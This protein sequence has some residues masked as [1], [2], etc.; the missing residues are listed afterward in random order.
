MEGKQH[1]TRAVSK[2]ALATV[3]QPG[4]LLLLLMLS[5]ACFP[6]LA[7]G[8]EVAVSEPAGWGE[9]LLRVVSLRDYNTRVVVLG[10]TV[11]GICGGVIGVFMLLRKRS[12]IGDV[13]GHSALPGIAMAFILAEA[14][15]PGSGRSLP[16]LLLGAVSSGLLG[17]LVVNCITRWTRLKPDAAMAIVLSLFYGAGT[18]LLTVVQRIPSGSS[19]GLK[20]FLIGKTASMLAEDAWVFAGAA[21]ILLVLTLLLFK[22]LCLIC[23]D[24]EFAASLGWNV[25]ALDTLLTG[26]VVGVTILG[27]QAVGLLLVVAIL[28]IPAAAARFWSERIGPMTVIAAGLGGLSAALG[29]FVSAFSPKLAAGAVIVLSG[30]LLFL[31][32]LLLGTYR[33][34]LWKSLEAHELKARIGQRDLLR[35]IYECLEQRFQVWPIGEPELM[36]TPVAI[37]D[38]LK[39]RSWQQRTL[40]KLLHRA[41][42]QDLLTIMPEGTVRLGP[43]GAVLARRV[44]RD[45]RLWEQYLINFAD[46]APSHVDRDAD[47]I[48]H[49]LASDVIRELELKLAESGPVRMPPS[50]HQLPFEP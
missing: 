34:I 20:D 33:G 41:E 26:M 23:F 43:N 47:Q 50:P 28:I 46:I 12:L 38:L 45:H 25:F 18:A 29:T 13:V 8:E 42:R 24:D 16:I 14:F 49:V 9:Q 48:E 35:A 40:H 11:L 5:G 3:R 7:W 31:V 30:T 4:M 37:D 36:T 19:A 27:M 15:L 6:Q 1:R 32:S 22:E 10:T 21:V 17:A 44:T 39:M 2:A